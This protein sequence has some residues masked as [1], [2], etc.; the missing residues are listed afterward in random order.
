MDLIYKSID[1]MINV[2]RR[3]D[4]EY[5]NNNFISASKFNKSYNEKLKKM[6]EG[7]NKDFLNIM[8][9]LY[10]LQQINDSLM[11]KKTG[12][13]HDFS[14]EIDQDDKVNDKVSECKSKNT[15]VLLF[16]KSSCPHC[17]RSKPVWDKITNE[18]SNSEQHKTYAI[19]L[20]SGELND[21]GKRINERP[22]SD[23]IRSELEN[24][25]VF[26]EHVPSMVVISKTSDDI[27]YLKY[28]KDIIEEN[29]DDIKDFIKDNSQ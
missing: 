26:L 7:S 19:K 29:Y 20:S 11:L 4:N 15:C 10:E 23:S 12:G 27:R 3:F 28:E 9:D 22:L 16:V 14:I 5:A 25:G 2:S 17:A 24:E 13:D 18:F 8:T 21:D 1:D 6:T